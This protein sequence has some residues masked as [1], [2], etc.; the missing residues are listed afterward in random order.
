MKIFQHVDWR[1]N[2]GDDLNGPFFDEVAPGYKSYSGH[3]RIYGIGTLLNNENGIIRNSVVFGSGYGYGDSVFCDE[4]TTKIIGVRG[5]LTAAALSLP[6]DKVI[7]D[8]AL[9][10]DK[11]RFAKNGISKAGDSK[12]V[13][14]TNHR[15]NELWN[16]N[17]IDSD[18]YFLDPGLI[19]IKDYVETIKNAK[20]VLAESLHGAIIASVY[21]V[22]FIPVAIR[23]GL[24][25]KK[26]VDFGS[27]IDM[28][29]DFEAI[30]HSPAISVMRKLCIS[31][32]RPN[33]SKII[34]VSKYGSDLSDSD[35]VAML[36]SIKKVINKT[37]PI[38]SNRLKVD[39]CIKK[40]E[41]AISELQCLVGG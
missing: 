32:F 6:S 2:F 17:N 27:A 37:R 24:E 35:V 1:G 16:F 39:N 4:R 11:L 20:L 3:D 40:I 8:P 28:E 21:G 33:I 10:I 26:W 13:I 15:S 19:S 31:R 38:V 25:Q 22:P 23:A 41:G 18:Y 12:I 9:Y 30:L 29:I 34:K 14:A 36:D 5:R 7:G